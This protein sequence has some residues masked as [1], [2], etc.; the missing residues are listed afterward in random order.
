MLSQNRQKQAE[1]GNF[2]G[3]KEDLEQSFEGIRIDER[4]QNRVGQSGQAGFPHDLFIKLC[5]KTIDSI[6]SAQV[7]QRQIGHQLPFRIFGFCT[8]LTEGGQSLL[9][10]PI[11]RPHDLLK[12]G[13]G[14]I[15][16][17]K[18]AEGTVH[19]DAKNAKP[20]LQT[21]QPQTHRREVEG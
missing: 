19:C 3:A 6:R 20:L 15:D 4:A 9:A 10:E 17:S 1:N 11:D 18:S 14:S 21:D 12:S 8:F 5:D 16:L 13:V 7:D 2:R